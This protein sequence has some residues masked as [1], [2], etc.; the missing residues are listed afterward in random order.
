[1]ETKT[2]SA[3]QAMSNMALANRYRKQVALLRVLTVTA[4]LLGTFIGWLTW[5]T[6]LEQP[7]KM[8]P[9]GTFVLAYTRTAW[10][11]AYLNENGEFRNAEDGLPLGTVIYWSNTP[12]E[13]W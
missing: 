3:A 10:Y 1:M 12:H 11:K 7:S 13:P 2:N 4:L 8:P 9:P 6:P 5:A